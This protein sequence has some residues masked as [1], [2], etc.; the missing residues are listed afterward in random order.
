MRKN[1]Y[2]SVIGVGSSKGVVH[3][4][5][6][7][8]QEPLLRILA[9]NANVNSLDFSRDGNYM[10]TGGSDRQFK[11]FDIRRTNQELYSY[12]TPKEA[13]IVRFSQTGL[14]GVASGSTIFYWK[15]SYLE[16]QKGPF[17]KH[18]DV[19]RLAINDMS[20]VPYEDFMGLTC[21]NKFESVFVPESGARDYDTFEDNLN[22]EKRQN[23]EIVVS[24]L[25]EKVF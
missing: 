15:D 21:F 11:L 24:K 5:S 25:L 1:P 2:N 13:S 6:P 14:V 23:R 20:F 12:H 22:S 7:N 9:H 4:Y 16:K 19:S 17:F 18:E 10:L 8:S 3:V